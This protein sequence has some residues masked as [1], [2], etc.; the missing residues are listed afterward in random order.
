MF[1][2]LLMLLAVTRVGAV[3]GPDGFVVETLATNL[4]AATALTVAPDGRIFIADQTGPLRVW[5][6][7]RLLPKPALELGDRVDDYWERGLVG[8]TLHPDFPHTPHLFVVYVAKKPFT[9]HVIS[10]FT[11]IGDQADVASELILLEGDDQKTLGGTVPHGHQ[12]GPIEGFDVSSWYGLFVPA[13]TPP[14]IIEKLHAD[15]SAVLAEPAVKAKL[16]QLGYSVAASTPDELGIQLKW[17]IGKW[18]TVI[19]SAGIGLAE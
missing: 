13:K 18:G 8:V 14:Q 6:N 9:R 19:R 2:W 11:M 5:K 16:E 17:E 12:G 15:T 7:G 3:E 10:R 4:N 1:K